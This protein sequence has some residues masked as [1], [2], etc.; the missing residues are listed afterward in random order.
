MK[1]KKGESLFKRSSRY[2]DRRGSGLECLEERLEAGS[3]CSTVKVEQCTRDG[4]RKMR[5]AVHELLTRAYPLQLFFRRDAKAHACGPVSDRR[6]GYVSGLG[7]KRR[8]YP[9][10]RP[11][12]GQGKER[13]RGAQRCVCWQAV[14]ESLGPR[15]AKSGKM[16]RGFALCPCSIFPPGTIG[17]CASEG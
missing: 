10:A 4:E 7:L 11:P 3:L 12:G 13:G 6:V 9:G 17:G 8:R 5:W 2:R 1:Q 15:H 14:V 16:R